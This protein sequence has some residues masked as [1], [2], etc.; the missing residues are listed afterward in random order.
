MCPCGFFLGQG[1]FFLK[2]LN[3]VKGGG[4]FVIFLVPTEP[5]LCG[6]CFCCLRRGHSVLM[7][8]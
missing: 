3:F 8:F 6:I 4:V 2:G 7:E 5:E 1:G